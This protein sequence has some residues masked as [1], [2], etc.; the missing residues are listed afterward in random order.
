M[1][2]VNEPNNRGGGETRCG[3]D[4]SQGTHPS[5]SP[6][7]QY[8][9]AHII[10]W[11]CFDNFGFP[12]RKKAYKQLTV[13]FPESSSEMEIKRFVIDIGEGRFREYNGKLCISVL[14]GGNPR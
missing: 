1:E 10:N 6:Q 12:P 2:L 5:S 4:W 14:F 8:Q 13:K 3:D 11:T 9:S 7:T